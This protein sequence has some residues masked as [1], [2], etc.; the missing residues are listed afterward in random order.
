MKTLSIILMMGNPDGQGSSLTSIILLLLFIGGLFWYF[1]IRKKTN[2]LSRPLEQSVKTESL[3]YPALRLIAGYLKLLAI[4]VAITTI[5]ILVV[6]T[7]SMGNNDIAWIP[8]AITL[9]S[10]AIIFI[11]LLANAEIIKVFIDIEE[12]T[13]KT[14][15]K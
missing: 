9:F 12:N 2:Q 11:I 14:S 5:I 13:R 4:I 7:K 6:I 8:S 10:G 15:M 3:K 1:L